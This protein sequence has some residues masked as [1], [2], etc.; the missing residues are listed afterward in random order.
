MKKTV[1]KRRKHVP[2]ASGTS[3]ST[4]PSPTS[5][6]RLAEQAA[7]EAL[8]SV[9]H[10]QECASGEES[11]AVSADDHEDGDDG[12]PRRKRVRRGAN[13]NTPASLVEERG[14]VFWWCRGV[15]HT[16]LD[17]CSFFPGFDSYYRFVFLVHIAQHK[18]YERLWVI[19]GP[20]YPK[21]C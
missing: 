16:V 4:N 2:A 19:F 1:I 20:P 11:G 5:N 12:E 9:S 21:L 8:V 13:G 18:L 14:S 7:A 17:V 15:G 3:A 10:A 6:A